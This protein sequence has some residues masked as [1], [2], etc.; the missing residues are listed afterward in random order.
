LIGG[1]IPAAKD[2]NIKNM[3]NYVNIRKRGRPRKNFE[4]LLQPINLFFKKFHAIQNFL[5]SILT[6]TNLSPYLHYHLKKIGDPI[7]EE[8]RFSQGQLQNFNQLGENIKILYQLL[9]QRS[10]IKSPLLSLKLKIKIM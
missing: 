5:E 4:D 6:S 9:P 3:H 8:L 1:K 7:E 2:R 10:P